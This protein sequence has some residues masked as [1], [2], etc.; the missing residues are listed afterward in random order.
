M[1]PE[2]FREGDCNVAECSVSASSCSSS[3]PPT[4]SSSSLTGRFPWRLTVVVSTGSGSHFFFAVGAAVSVLSTSGE[5]RLLLRLVS[6]GSGANF[7]ELLVVVSTG[8]G[9]NLRAGCGSGLLVES[10]AT[11]LVMACSWFGEASCGS[12]LCLL[13]DVVSIGSGLNFLEVLVDSS[14]G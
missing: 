5:A 11:V 9:M 10:W 2:A 1:G 8:R 6:T 4:T 13:L 7:L 14:T 12:C 3:S